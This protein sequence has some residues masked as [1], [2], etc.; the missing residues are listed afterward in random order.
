MK[1]LK[2]SSKSYVITLTKEGIEGLYSMILSAQ[3][4]ERRMFN[5]L[6]EQ[7]KKEIA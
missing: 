7:I 3:L 2:A 1:L 6:K 4:P 5:D